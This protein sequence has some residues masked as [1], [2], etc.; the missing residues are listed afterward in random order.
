MF[1]SVQ[2]SLVSGQHQNTWFCSRILPAD[3]MSGPLW[4]VLVSVSLKLHEGDQEFTAMKHSPAL[5][6]DS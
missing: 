6:W 1:Q 4:K 2:S 5:T 3:T